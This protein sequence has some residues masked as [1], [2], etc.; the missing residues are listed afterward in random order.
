MSDPASKV[1]TVIDNLRSDEVPA[2]RMQ[3]VKGSPPRRPLARSERAW[4]EFQA[5]VKN[6]RGLLLETS[7]LGSKVPHRVLCPAGH[8]ATPSPNSVQRGNGLC[9]ACAGKDPE[10]AWREF[11]ARVKALG[12][13]VLEPYWLGARTPPQGRV[14]GRPSH[15][16]APEQRPARRRSLPH[17]R[18]TRS[19]NRVVAVPSPSRR[20][21]RHGPRT[22]LARQRCSPPGQVCCRA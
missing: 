21:G 20:A 8:L 1:W 18:R 12:G 22:R 2:P 14:R 6:L 13:R 15:E 19:R 16:P 10:A 17:L 4:R 11:Q 7:W 9:R 5:R 3:R